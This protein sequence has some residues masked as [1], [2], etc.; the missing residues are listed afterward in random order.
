MRKVRIDWNEVEWNYWIICAFKDVVCHPWGE[1][2]L[3]MTDG[4]L[5]FISI[6]SFMFMFFAT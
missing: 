6:V 2:A 5:K 4:N 1:L 3:I